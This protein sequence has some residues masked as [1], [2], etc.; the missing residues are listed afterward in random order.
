MGSNPTPRAYLVVLSKNNKRQKVRNSNCKGQLLQQPHEISRLKKTSDDCA[1]HYI[2]NETLSE[3][4]NSITNTCSKSYFNQIL[5]RLAGMNSK[6]ANT[7]CEYII[8]E[9]DQ[10]NIKNST[11]EGKIKTLVWLSNFLEDKVNFRQMSKEN[12]LRYLTNGKKSLEQDKKQRWIGTYNNRQMILLK[13]F[14]WLYNPNEI[15]SK[16]MDTPQCMYGI[17]QLPRQDSIA[18]KPS[19]MWYPKENSVFLTYCPSKRDRCYHAMATD[20]SCRP[21]E[22]LNLKIS[23]IIFKRTDNGRMYAEIEIKGG[24][25]RVRT[26]PLIESV[27]FVRDWIKSHPTEDNPD[28]W[29][30][31]SQ[32]NTTYGSKLTYDGLSYRYKYFYK[33]RYFAKLLK[34]E[35]VSDS[36]KSVMRSMLAKP[37]NLYIFRHSSLTEKSTYLKEHILRA[38]AG[39]TLS[40]KMPQTYI[41]YFG[42]ESVNSLLEAKGVISKMNNTTESLFKICS[43]C[44]EQVKPNAKFC[45]SCN[46]ILSYEEYSSTLEKQR[47][48]ESE[49]QLL[50]KSLNQEIETLKKQISRDIKKQMSEL[51]T[52]L[53]PEIIQQWLS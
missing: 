33:H 42:N 48:K 53:K 36:D 16:R 34:D 35:S 25:S 52:Q 6:N 4:I 9:Q 47:E 29:L 32:S 38:H 18:Y 28:S 43:N 22:L 41:H 13:F 39:W 14:K 7:I 46:M 11:K 12:I 2:T 24:K 8:S 31:I 19:D 21:H 51:L 40:S 5:K 45:S 23:D 17:K 37:W 20:T 44:N 50:K 10:R 1:V 26:V 30:F 27:P 3:K 49:I 15:D